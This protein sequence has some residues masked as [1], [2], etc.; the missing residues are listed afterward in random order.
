MRYELK[1][2]FNNS[3]LDDFQK[4]LYQNSSFK[5]K[6]KNR[7]VNSLYFDDLQN[8]SANDNLS[9]ISKRE[10][11]RLR[12]YNNNFEN[13]LKFEIKKRENRLNYKEFFTFSD[14]EKKSKS[15]KYYTSLCEK[16]LYKH[17]LRYIFGLFP[18]IQV[19]YNRE[20]LEDKNS[21]RITIDSNIKFWKLIEKD[22]FFNGQYMNYKFNIVEIKFEPDLYFYTSNILRQTNFIPKRHSKYL[23][24]LSI[25]DELKYI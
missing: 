21:L 19:Q 23:V 5:K 6:Y 24:G 20:Y 2:I 3:Q 4:W 17:N 1:F 22:S 8:S 10:K 12:W 16:K 9:G 11:Y 14:D 7:I 25:F 13:N 15:L 18:K